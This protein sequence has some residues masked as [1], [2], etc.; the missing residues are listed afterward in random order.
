MASEKESDFENIP[1]GLGRRLTNPQSAL[2]FD[3]EGADSHHM[4]IAPAPTIAGP[5][6]A[7]ELAELYWMALSRDVHF[8]DYASDA[9]TRAAAA[10][11]SASPISAD[12][13]PAAPSLP[14]LSFGGTRRAIWT[15][16]G[17]RSFSGWTSR[18]E[19]CSSRRRCRPRSSATTT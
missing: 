16:P 5:R 4:A 3:L 6:A 7:S 8:S 2:A 12:P 1:L 14:A 17:S 19:R 13:S 9:T 11:L 18:W 10:D 15:V